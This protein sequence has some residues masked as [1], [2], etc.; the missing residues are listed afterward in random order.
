MTFR[1]FLPATAAPTLLVL[2]VASAAAQEASSVAE[3]HIAWR[4]CLNRNFVLEVALTSRVI[5]ADAALR[6]CRPSEQAYLAALAASPLVDGDEGAQ[7][8]P[9]LRQRARGGLL[10][11][12][13]QRPL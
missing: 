11:G 2:L 4:A 13:R 1:D 9:A 12:G 3:R 7:V 5:A 10:E 8:R 6:T